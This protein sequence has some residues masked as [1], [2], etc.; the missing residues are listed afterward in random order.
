MVAMRPRVQ[1]RRLRPD[2]IVPRYMTAGAAGMD[3][4]AAIDAPVTIAPGDRAS[5]STG[6]AMHIPDGFEGQVRPRSGLAREHG[7]TLVNSPGTIDC[8]YRGPV[9]VLLVNLGKAPVTIE[10]GHRIAQLVIAPV[11]QPELEEVEELADSSRGA[12]GFGSTGR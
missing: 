1:F 2:A 11:V 6:L 9:T 10:N 3:L 7:I 4:C 8:D 5:I 12:G